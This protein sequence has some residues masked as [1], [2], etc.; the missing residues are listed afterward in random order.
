MQTEAP[1]KEFRDAHCAT[2]DAEHG[3]VCSCRL[4]CAAAHASGNAVTFSYCARFLSRRWSL[5]CD[6][7]GAAVTT[8]TPEWRAAEPLTGADA[9][10]LSNA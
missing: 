9:I 8:W 1:I 2:A 3:D 4:L 10:L 7:G 6:H 5:R